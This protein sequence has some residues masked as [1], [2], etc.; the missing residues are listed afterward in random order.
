MSSIS[1]LQLSAQTWKG[2]FTGVRETP[3]LGANV[4]CLSGVI[5][6]KIVATIF[7]KAD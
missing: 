2:D 5:K 3:S 7:C 1:R 6:D 4:T